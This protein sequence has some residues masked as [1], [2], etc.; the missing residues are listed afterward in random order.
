MEKR[1][2]AILGSTGSIGRQT[3]DVVRAFPEHFQVVA[4]AARGNIELLAE[5]AH[6]FG[7]SLVAEMGA[8]CHAI[9]LTDPSDGDL[10]AR[11]QPGAAPPRVFRLERVPE[12]AE[13]E[14]LAAE[15]RRVEPVT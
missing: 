12:A 4:L 6:E 3:L 15:L 13:L 1:R 14:R 7:P 5:Q 10:A 9:L 11:L 2:I 8:K